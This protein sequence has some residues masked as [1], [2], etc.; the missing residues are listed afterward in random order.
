LS[1]SS[2]RDSTSV[3]AGHAASSAQEPEFTGKA[4]FSRVTKLHEFSNL[5]F[6]NY[7]SSLN[8]LLLFFH[9]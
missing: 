5:F 3:S 8:F 7:I 1:M 6:G 4:V 9:G 2:R